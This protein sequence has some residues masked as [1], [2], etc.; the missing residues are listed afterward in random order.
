MARQAALIFER[1]GICVGVGRINRYRGDFAMLGLKLVRL[2]EKHSAEI[3]DGL[4][5]KLRTSE[6]TPGYRNLR[7]DDL[8]A[9]LVSLYAH[10]EDWLLTKTESDV[11]KHFRNIGAKRAEEGIPPSE[12]AWALMMSKVQLW[13]FVYREAAAEKALELYGELEFLETLD[14]FF[15]RAVYYT[16]TGYEQ[17]AR[18]AKAA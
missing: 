6:R 1:G 11:E 15:D 14:R 16:L 4:M 18:M 5:T 2:I 13:A 17:H 7:E 8:R 9:A 10:L 3:A 12:V